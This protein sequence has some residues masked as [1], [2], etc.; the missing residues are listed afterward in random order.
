MLGGPP[1]ILKNGVNEGGFLYVAGDAT[2]LE[3]VTQADYGVVIDSVGRYFVYGQTNPG[4]QYR[5]AQYGF[6]QIE[7]PFVA[8]KTP[9][10]PTSQ[11]SIPIMSTQELPASPINNGVAPGVP[12]TPTM[13]VQASTSTTPLPVPVPAA[14]APAKPGWLMPAALAIGA[15]LAIKGEG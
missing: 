13:A 10:G 14:I 1:W 4:D 15:W 9:L 7:D 11:A 8:V 5:A 2:P 12:N 6:R 3:P